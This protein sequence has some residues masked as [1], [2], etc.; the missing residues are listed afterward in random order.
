MFV[1][2]VPTNWAKPRVVP[3]V[4]PV[5]VCLLT[6]FAA[7]QVCCFIGF[8]FVGAF[9][10]SDGMVYIG[11]LLVPTPISRCRGCKSLRGACAEN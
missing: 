9:R 8:Q 4:Q 7:D 5:L 11:P 1:V 3:S 10:Y 2:I 6:V